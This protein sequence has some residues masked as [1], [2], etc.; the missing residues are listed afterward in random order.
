MHLRQSSRG[1]KP[2]SSLIILR[3]DILRPLLQSSPL[4]KILQLLVPSCYLLRILKLQFSSH[5]KICA[6]LLPAPK[7]SEMAHRI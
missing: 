6:W 1:L 7:S 2:S 3:C 5:L 4:V